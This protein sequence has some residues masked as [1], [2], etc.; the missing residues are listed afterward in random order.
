MKRKALYSMFI[1][2]LVFSIATVSGAAPKKVLFINSYH[3]GYAWSDGVIRGVLGALN[4]T[5]NADGT[6]DNS[7][8]DV[9][10]KLFHMDTKRNT[11]AEF[12]QAAALRAKAE[13]EAWQ[14][15]VVI[16]S[17]DAASKYL[18]APYLKDTEL[19]V[20]FCAVN[21]EAS[22]YG[23]PTQNVTGMVEV[24]LIPQILEAVKPYAQGDR[25]AHLCHDNL[26][27]RKT[28]TYFKDVFH[29]N[30]IPKFVNSFDE[31]KTAFL[32]LQQEADVIIFGPATFSDWDE[33]AAIKLVEARSTVPSGV[34]NDFLTPIALVGYVK[35]PEEQGEWAAQAALKI[36]AGTSPADIPVATNTKGK[37]YLNMRIA[38]TLGV[39]FPL[40][41]VKQATILK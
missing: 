31:W 25:V 37:I 38:E 41:L 6:V 18:I 3:P 9:E 7:A 39:K 17:D 33:Q 34:Y 29:L 2:I 23:F 40:K 13:I 24:S 27:N 32:Q 15:D 4:A 16:A 36:L 19:P 1:G 26:T 28:T 12:A 14:P 5:L 30:V 21:W 20:V 11:S 8:S 35:V 10:L 22:G